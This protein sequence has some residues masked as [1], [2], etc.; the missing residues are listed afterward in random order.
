MAK[1]FEDLVRKFMVDL[2]RNQTPA[3]SSRQR[4]WIF[5]DPKVHEAE[6][7]NDYDES[8]K[9][10]VVVLVADKILPTV[11]HD[12]S[13]ADLREDVSVGDAAQNI[14]DHWTN[15]AWKLHN[16]HLHRHQIG[17]L[18]LRFTSEVGNLLRD[19]VGGYHLIHS[20]PSIVSIGTLA[21]GKRIELPQQPLCAVLDGLGR[22]A[23]LAAW[24]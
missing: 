23:H 5:R 19:V 12:G 4:I 24:A 15:D 21:G 2:C 1:R 17:E 11:F 3:A 10:L 9:C 18:R 16:D 13:D 6:Q 7:Q 20:V 22:Q 14:H 8:L